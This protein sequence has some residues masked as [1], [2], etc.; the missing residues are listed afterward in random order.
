MQPNFLIVMVDQLAGT[1]LSR[2]PGRRSCTRRRWPARRAIRPLQRQLLREPALRALARRLHV[3]AAAVAHR[4]LRQRRRVP[5]LASRPSRIICAA[6][7]TAPR[8]AG[9]MHFVGPD[10][11]HGFEERL[12]TDIYPA[13][14]GWTPDWTKPDE[15]IDWWYHNLASV[16]AGGRGGD[17]QPD[18]IRRGGRAFRQAAH[19]RLRAQG[20]RP[21]VL[22]DGQLHPSARSLCDA[23][24]ATGISTDDAIIPMPAARDLLRGAGSAF[25]AHSRFAATSAASMSAKSTSAPPAAPISPRSPTS[26]RRSA[27]CSTR[28][29]PAASPRTR[30]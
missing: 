10:Q 15:R 14:F 30:S 18:R 6:S 9:K 3:R 1:L 28:W 2:R 16:T 26:T 8:S 21:A 24:A 27:S 5:L 22:P 13:D 4:R 19:L 25:A 12:T 29:R 11:L 17:D 23:A 20:R 7:A